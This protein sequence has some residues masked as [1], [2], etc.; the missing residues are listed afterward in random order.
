ME[1]GETTAEAAARETLEEANARVKIGELYSMYSLPYINQVH[2][3]FRAELLDLDFSPGTES[4]EVKLLSES[5]IPWNEIAFRPIR[6]S[7]EYYFA[8]RG[9]GQFN[10]HIGELTSPQRL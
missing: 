8:E 7:L 3:L 2:L 6:F 1:N 9:S 5:E 4:L 10:F